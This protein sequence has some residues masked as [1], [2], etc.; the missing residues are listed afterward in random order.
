MIVIS[1]HLYDDAAKAVQISN[2]NDIEN[3]GMTMLA[4]TNFQ[5]QWLWNH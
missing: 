4:D 2:P 3:I 5:S 1:G